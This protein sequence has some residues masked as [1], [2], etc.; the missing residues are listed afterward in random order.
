MEIGS[1]KETTEVVVND[2]KRRSGEVKNKFRKSVEEGFDV[3]EE[4]KD[5]DDYKNYM[6]ERLEEI[7]EKKKK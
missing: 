5:G 2:G 4:Q 1:E 3:D 6:Q 7:L